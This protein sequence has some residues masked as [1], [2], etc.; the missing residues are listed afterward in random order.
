M[1]W[2]LITMRLLLHLSNLSKYI[3]NNLILQAIYFRDDC[4]AE[5]FVNIN[6]HENWVCPLYFTREE[7]EMREFTAAK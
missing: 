1:L 6:S 4:K 5:I 3:V 7:S 2:V